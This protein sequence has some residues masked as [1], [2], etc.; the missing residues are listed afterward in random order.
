MKTFIRNLLTDIHMHI[1]DL[2]CNP[3][4]Q[5]MHFVF[6]SEA[7]ENWCKAQGDKPVKSMHS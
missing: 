2:F 1:L 7:Q 5:V 3:K 6:L 4:Q